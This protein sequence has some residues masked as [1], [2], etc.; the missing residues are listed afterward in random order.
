MFLTGAYN[1][2]QV[3]FVLLTGYEVQ[4]YKLK[5]T[6]QQRGAGE[7]IDNRNGQKLDNGRKY[8]VRCNLSQSFYRQSAWHVDKK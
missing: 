1:D 5:T 2:V 6:H 4:R 3:E 7:F 8:T